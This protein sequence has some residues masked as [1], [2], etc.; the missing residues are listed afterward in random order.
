MVDYRKN[1]D[2]LKEGRVRFM[3]KEGDKFNSKFWRQNNR[4]NDTRHND[5]QKNGMPWLGSNAVRCHSAELCQGECLLW[6]VS[7]NFSSFY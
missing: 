2:Y 3:T 7:F 5:I 1:R 6:I 4:Q